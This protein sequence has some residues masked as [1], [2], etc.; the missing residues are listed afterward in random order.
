MMKA[1]TDKERDMDTDTA[2]NQI[3]A[4]KPL[5]LPVGNSDWAHVAAHN[6][7][8][9]KTQLISGLLDRDATVALFTRPRRFGKTP[10]D[11]TQLKR[12]PGRSRFELVKALAAMRQDNPVFTDVNGSD[13]LVWLDTSVPESVTAFVR[14]NG[15]DAAIVVQNWTDKSVACAVSFDVPKAATASYLAPEE[16]DRSVH[17][18]I[19]PEPLF[20][21]DASY[22]P[23]SRFTIG[24]FECW[25]SK[26]RLLERQ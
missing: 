4:K 2:E 24:P 8:A 23:D 11:W 16:T 20:T 10:M 1:A 3:P 26:I 5:P 7:C 13:G 15:R 12:E 6:W 17:G 19:A 22:L 18:D 14:R 21:R 25:I 9:D